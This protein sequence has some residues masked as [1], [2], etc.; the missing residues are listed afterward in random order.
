MG[1]VT[2]AT[3]GP[4]LKKFVEE[5]G[6]ILAIGTSSLFG[7]Y[8]GIPVTSALTEKSADGKD[9][10]LPTMKFYVPGSVLQASVDN[11]VP[12]SYGMPD[13]A[14]V[15]Y[16]NSPAFKLTP[17]ADLKNT[18]TIMSFNTPHPLRSGWAWGEE[19]LEG[20]VE[21]VDEKVGEGHVYLFGPEITF[22]GQP[23]GTFKF[24]FNAIDL[25]SEERVTRAASSRRPECL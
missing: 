25:R 17:G 13:K 3:T 20:A 5:G 11:T 15:F 24:L 18:H 8:L 10:R 14:D 2:L 9:V 4:Q 23:H 22:R 6:T 7:P 19:H 21:A 16:D 1:N 12:I